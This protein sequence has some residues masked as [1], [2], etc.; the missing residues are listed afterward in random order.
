VDDK[1]VANKIDYYSRLAIDYDV[2]VDPSGRAKAVLQV[3]LTNE[4]PPGLPRAIANPVRNGGYAV[5]RA[6]ML[7]LVPGNAELLEAVPDAG[8][9]DHLEAGRRVFA[10]ILEARPGKATTLRL[11]YSMVGVVVSRG[12]GNLYRLTIQHQPRIAP[13][14]LRVRVTLPAGA[15][16]HHAP[17]GWIVKG[18]VLTLTTKLTRD[19]VQDIV[20]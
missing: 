11:E 14:D 6:L 16:I 10:R 3:T 9:P 2:R 4:S 20:F 1:L 19:L 7:A 17:R 8:L 5:N 18:N 13:A 15:T 12:A